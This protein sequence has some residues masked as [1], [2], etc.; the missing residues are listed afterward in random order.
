M[1]SPSASDNVP[2]ATSSDRTGMTAAADATAPL[3]LPAE[4]AVDTGATDADAV[5]RAPWDAHSHVAGGTPTS[6]TLAT[7]ARRLFRNQDR[8]F[9]T[10]SCRAARLT[11]AALMGETPRRRAMSSDRSH[12]RLT[13][14][15]MP[16]ENAAIAFTADAANS[17]GA[18][19]ATISL[20]SMY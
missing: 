17:S 20:F 13:D 14:L 11:I 1:V 18:N 2:L 5:I 4:R 6:S 9:E 8:E 7:T 16:S 12:S 3:E 15:G 19:A 10:L